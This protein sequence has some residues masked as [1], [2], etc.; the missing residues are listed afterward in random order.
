MIF[1]TCM[2]PI[3]NK[4]QYYFSTQSLIQTFSCSSWISPAYSCSAKT[5][6]IQAFA[7]TKQNKSKQIIIGVSGNFFS[8]F[9]CCLEEFMHFMLLWH[10][11]QLNPLSCWHCL[12]LA[13][14]FVCHHLV[15]SSACS[16]REIR[17]AWSAWSAWSGIVLPHDS[18]AIS[19]AVCICACNPKLLIACHRAVSPLLSH[20]VVCWFGL[21][22]PILLRNFSWWFNLANGDLNAAIGAKRFVSTS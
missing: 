10:S 18:G 4:A 20:L 19:E 17:K 1:I 2:L 8:G 5:I 12:Y 6:I 22:A 13:I 3:T 14:L 15:W 7:K 21:H 11:L 16:A 9:V